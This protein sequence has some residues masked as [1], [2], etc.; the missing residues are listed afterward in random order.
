MAQ[1]VDIPA[2]FRDGFARARLLDAGLA[3]RYA[4]HLSLGDPLADAAVAAAATARQRPWIQ[5]GLD[6]GLAGL[7]DAPQALRDL[8]AHATDVPYWFTQSRTLPGCR[9]F[10]GNSRMFLAAFVAGSLV[11]AYSTLIAKAFITSGRLGD[12]AGRR[13]R[14]NNQL[15][16]EIFLPGGLGEFG[17]G[18]K[19]ALR[20]RL[21]HARL[22]LLT[23]RSA[24][25]NHEDWG[26]PLNAAHIAFMN[27]ALSGRLL[28][29]ARVLG[30]ELFPEERRAFMMIWRMAGHLTGVPAEL[31]PRHEIEAQQLFRIGRM[32][33]PPPEIE[34]IVLANGL[35]NSA[36]M[37]AGVDD[38]D[39]R[40]KLV[41][42]LY[43]ISRGLIGGDLAT[44]LH[45]PETR[46]MDTLTAIRLRNRADLLLRRHIG[47][48]DR[49]RRAGQFTQLLDLSFEG[50]DTGLP[51]AAVEDEL[52]A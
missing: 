48:Y 41:R 14:Q 51:Q 9:A 5:I 27:A 29:R 44:A 35:I 11:E 7:D 47:F 17:E 52:P 28:E 8:F 33:E 49:R 2:A 34:G 20:I 40:R 26:T 16:S 1:V 12:Q 42:Q 24:D 21:M 30:V 46:G 10:H 19:M 23:A 6:E 43:G 18:W 50:L 38:P 32:M 22:R 4:R 39:L 31:L 45:F 15:L 25:W 3:E 37:A 36:P 13:F